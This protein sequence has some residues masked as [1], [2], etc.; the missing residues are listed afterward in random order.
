MTLRTL[1]VKSK[2][3]QSHKLNQNFVRSKLSYANITWLDIAKKVT[4][5]HSPTVTINSKQLQNI[6]SACMVGDT[7]SLEHLVDSYTKTKL[8]NYK[9]QT[10]CKKCNHNPTNLKPYTTLLLLHQLKATSMTM[11]RVLKISMLNQSPMWASLHKI[12]K[13]HTLV[14]VTSWVLIPWEYGVILSHTMNTHG[15]TLKKNE[16]NHSIK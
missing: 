2:T 9:C 13:V 7:A 6:K 11:P 4:I 12:T 16:H 14:S 8:K 10:K 15:P 3:L 5:V 1:L